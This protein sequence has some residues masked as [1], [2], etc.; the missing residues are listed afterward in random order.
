MSFSIWLK[1]S[2]NWASWRLKSPKI[3]FFYS[4]TTT[5][6]DQQQMKYQSSSLLTLCA[7]N[8]SV[9][10]NFP[11]QMASTVRYT[12]YFQS[13]A[14]V[15]KEH[16]INQ[17]SAY[18]RLPNV[19]IIQH[20]HEILARPK[21]GLFRYHVKRIHFTM[22]GFG[23]LSAILRQN[24]WPCTTTTTEVPPLFNLA[25]FDM[26]KDCCG[27]NY[28]QTDSDYFSHSICSF[29]KC[30]SIEITIQLNS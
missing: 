25:R 8:S 26:N 12:F 5:S 4:T 18:I 7:K 2:S 28:L 17:C 24:W 15:G 27:K 1:F 19:G 23:F 21:G 14:R 22:Q 3:R 29:I 11:S 9:T 13:G 6:P 30:I 20:G 10:D 16:R